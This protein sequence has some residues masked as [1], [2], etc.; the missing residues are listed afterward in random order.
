MNLE[1]YLKWG[2]ALES[3]LGQRDANKIQDL[4]Y[5]E[6]WRGKD[7]LH[8]LLFQ[9]DFFTFPIF[10]FDSWLKPLFQDLPYEYLYRT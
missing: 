6:L 5:V 3:N 2:F 9:N 1:V 10:S 4:F 7:G 8:S